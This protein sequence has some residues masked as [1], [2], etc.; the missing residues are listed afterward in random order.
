M[1][2]FSIVLLF[3]LLY[4]SAVAEVE[5]Y[6]VKEG[7]TLGDIAKLKY[8]EFILWIQLAKY[9]DISNPDLIM[10]GREILVP[11]KGELISKS[12]MNQSLEARIEKLEKQIS[13]LQIP[14]ILL[15]D[16]FEDYSV[17]QKPDEW[18]FPSG[19]RWGI[20]ASGSRMLQQV[21]RRPGNS[22]ALTGEKDWSDYTVQTELMVEYSGE[23]GVFACWNS[24]HE[25]YRLRTNDRHGVIEIAKRV[26]KGPDRYDT[27]ILN[28][29]PF[30][31]LDKTWYIF[32]LEVTSQKSYVYLKGKVW[33]KGATE[34]GTWLIETSDH[35]SE[36]Y[37]SGLAGVWTINSGDSYKGAKFDNFKVLR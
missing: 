26:P 27:I 6:K 23:V 33:R 3:V 28:R 9:N 11:P 25:N 37:E 14:E 8:D 16:N 10:T 17:G 22:A 4:G 31:M 13:R 30:Q 36:R 32:K 5:V 1:K 20:S 7:D 2:I 21:D 15:E 29:M 35:S 12:K 18:L 34:P 19:G 24:H